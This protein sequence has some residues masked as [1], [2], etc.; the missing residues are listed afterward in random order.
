MSH[1]HRDGYLE[2][3]NGMVLVPMKWYIILNVNYIVIQKI[4]WMYLSIFI[5]MLD[6]QAG[7]VE[8]FFSL[9]R[10]AFFND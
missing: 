2:E 9:L 8:G 5:L 1:L 7:L 4:Q 10:M 3:R 6:S